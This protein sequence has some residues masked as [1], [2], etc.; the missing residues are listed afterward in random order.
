[1]DLS[2]GALQALLFA[3]FGTATAALAAVIGPTY[4]YLFVPELSPGSLFPGLTGTGGGGFL[5]TPATFSIYV[6]TNLVDPALVLVGVGVGLL[7]LVRAVLPRPRPEL[8]GLLGR[9]VVAVI[10]SNVTLPIAGAILALAAATY[11]VVAGFDG[12]AWQHWQNLG[13]FGLL[14]Y[15][16][17]NGALAFVMAFVLFS[18]VLLLAVAIAVR[19]ALLG[20]LI[21]LL[22]V[23]TILWPLPIVGT[24][25]KR[26]WL[27]FVEL[28]FLPCVLV[29]PLELAVGSTSVLLT[30]AYLLVALGSPALL[31]ITASSLVK[32]GWPSAGGALTGGIQRGLA[33]ASVAVEGAVR[34]GT[35]ALRTSRRAGTIGAALERSAQRPGALAIPALTNELLGHGSARLFRHVAAHVRPAR[36]GLRAGRGWSAPALRSRGS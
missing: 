2:S 28:A 19:N 15:S 18:L 33:A 3:L 10:V 7:Y 6:L 14:Q 34:P 30:T 25:A 13:G 8:Q 24:L 36:G 11:P 31:Q 26:G 35:A 5:A 32:A 4:D 23:F 17:D 29:I 16:W 20:V 22:P 9:L 12:G 21:V 1:M 27:W